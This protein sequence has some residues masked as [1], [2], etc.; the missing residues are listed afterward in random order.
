MTPS[1]QP[2]QSIVAKPSVWNPFVQSSVHCSKW[3]ERSSSTD[4]VKTSSYVLNGW[5]I[6]TQ[7]SAVRGF[8]SGFDLVNHALVNG[9]SG[10]KPRYVRVGR[11]VI[12]YREVLIPTALEEIG[13][14]FSIGGQAGLFEQV[15]AVANAL[16]TNISSVSNEFA[17]RSG[18]SLNFPIQPASLDLG[19]CQVDKVIGIH[20]QLGE[21]VNFECFNIGQAGSGSQA[22]V[23]VFARFI[24]RRCLLVYD[25]DT[26]IFV[27]V[28]LNEFLIAELVKCG[29][30]E[31]DF[32]TVAT[33]IATS[34]AT[35]V[36]S[37]AAASC[38][39][40]RNA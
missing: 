33:T 31:R 17:V 21:P 29:Y 28:F 13:Y 27:H 1:I 23:Q 9:S 34:A 32:I 25:L 40:E 39:Y 36:S 14:F 24:G 30:R 35:G 15:G 5:V 11:K 19:V 3:A 10:V 38:G 16:G 18:G 37:I 6:D 12:A 22:R 4:A 2:G 26:R 7:D 8:I 20:H